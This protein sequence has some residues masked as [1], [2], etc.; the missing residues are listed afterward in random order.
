[1]WG[2]L[3]RSLAAVGISQLPALIPQLAALVPPPW[4]LA[5]IPILMA[6]SKGL[7]DSM[8]DKAPWWT[9]IF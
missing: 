3:L 4:N 9:K 8:G 6:T 7:R 5:V 1:M 2:R